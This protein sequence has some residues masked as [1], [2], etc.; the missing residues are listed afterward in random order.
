M[1]KLVFLRENPNASG[2]AELYLKWLKASFENSRIPS[3]IRGFS[4]SKKLASW[5]KALLFNK[6]AR[7]KKAP[8]ELYFSLARIDSSDIYSTDDVVHK[9]YRKSKKFWWL[10]PINFVHPYLEKKCFE[11]AK[12]IIAISQM[13]KK[14][15]IECY[16]VPESKIEVLYNGVEFPKEIDKK[17]AKKQLYARLGLDESEPLVLFVGSGF[18]RKG[19]KELLLAL[20]EQ[21]SAYNA[22]FVGKDKQLER[23]KNLAKSLSVKAHFLGASDGASEYFE[24]CDILALLSA[25]E[26][27]GLVVLEAM[28]YGCAVIASDKCGAAEL[29]DREFIA[30]DSTC[31]SK[32]LAGL[33]TNSQKLEQ[34][35]LKNRQKAQEHS[36]EANVKAQIELVRRYL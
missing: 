10:N 19:V 1:K 3:Q 4:G 27:F 11:N 26:P 5:I 35:G 13:V 15:I 16:S 14:Q 7:A 33:L 20:S 24:A 6:E 8:D 21:K 18:K 31:A 22:L 36:L 23:Y 17:S 29:L 32:I 9:V 34:A 25:Y 28:S 12:C 2:G 30:S